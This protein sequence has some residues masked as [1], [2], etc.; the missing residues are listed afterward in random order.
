MTEIPAGAQRPA[1]H[2]VRECLLHQRRAGGSGRPTGGP[3]HE[4]PDLRRELTAQARTASRQLRFGQVDFAA[5][6]QDISPFDARS[7]CTSNR[8]M[9]CPGGGASG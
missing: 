5:T 2:R 1:V 7:G 8:P 9:A 6:L 3:K 4:L